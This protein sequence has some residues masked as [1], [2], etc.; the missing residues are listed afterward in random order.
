MSGPFNELQRVHRLV[1]VVDRRGDVAD[2]EGEGVMGEG[3]L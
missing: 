3:L 1:D 2:D